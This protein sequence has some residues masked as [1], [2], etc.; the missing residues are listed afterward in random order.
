MCRWC[1]SENPVPIPSLLTS[2]WRPT[3]LWA[4]TESSFHHHIPCLHQC[5]AY[6]SVHHCRSGWFEWECRYECIEG[7]GWW[8]WTN[9]EKP[10]FNGQKLECCETVTGVEPPNSSQPSPSGV[11]LWCAPH[12]CVSVAWTTRDGV[13]MSSYTLNP[14]TKT[15]DKK[16]R[17]FIVFTA[18][19]VSVSL[20]CSS[21][22]TGSVQR[23]YKQNTN[24]FY[25]C[26]KPNS[27]CVSNFCQS[28]F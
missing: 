13:L 16:V 10:I 27:F 20:T 12:Q 18:T 21:F 11:A 9:Q 17:T 2:A 26:N 22:T 4:M 6:L 24:N 7:N 3:R 5:Y 19:T 1:T 28:R 8:T 23:L 25:N 14:K 15:Q